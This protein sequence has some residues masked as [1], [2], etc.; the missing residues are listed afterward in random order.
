MSPD[1][2]G[3]YRQDIFN[4]ELAAWL[5][6]LG[7]MSPEFVRQRDNAAFW[8]GWLHSQ[9]PD[10]QPG[11]LG[12][13]YI[14]DPSLGRSLTDTQVTLPAPFDTRSV[15]CLIELYRSR[16]SKHAGRLN[17]IMV[18]A[19]D[20]ASGEEKRSRQREEAET[21]GRGRRGDS[22]L[23]SQPHALPWWTITPFG[24]AE[25][26]YPGEDRTS[27]QNRP[28]SGE[29]DLQDCQAEGI[30]AAKRQLARI[31]DGQAPEFDHLRGR[32]NAGLD[33]SSIPVCDVRIAD[34]SL[35]ASAFAKAGVVESLL[36]GMW[37]DERIEWRLLRLAVDGLGFLAMPTRIPEVL[38][39]Q[40][41]LRDGLD[42]LRAF[43]ERD[44]LCGTEVYRDEY[45]PVFVVPAFDDDHQ[46][47][48]FDAWLLGRL[49]P[50]WD[51]RTGSEL[52]WEAL[53][54]K[55]FGL[56]SGRGYAY[57]LGSLLRR[58]PPP[59]SASPGA[60]TADWKHLADGHQTE[61]CSACQ[62]RPIGT[63]PHAQA[64]RI[65][66]VCYAGRTKR[67]ESWLRQPFSTI[68][69]E[70]VADRNGRIAVVAARF[71]AED[72]LSREDERPSYMES[73]VFREK[74]TGANPRNIA[75][76]AA[77]TRRLFETLDDFWDLLLRDWAD[78]LRADRKRVQLTPKEGTWDKHNAYDL[79]SRTSHIGIA[80]VWTGEAFVIVENPERLARN[81]S[82]HED[83]WRESFDVWL[84]TG[85]RRE[86]TAASRAFCGSFEVRDVKEWGAPFTRVIEIEHDPRQFLALVPADAALSCIGKVEGRYGERFGRVRNRLAVDI[87]II[88]AGVETPLRA[89]LDAARRGLRRRS[90]PAEWHV[91]CATSVESANAG[92]RSVRLR[93]DNGV[94]W[95]IPLDFDFE[96]GAESNGKYTRKH[97]RTP[98]DYFAYFQD[99]DGCIAHAR[100]LQ[101][102]DPVLVEPSTFDFEFLD[103]SSRR[104]DLSYDESGRRRA[105]DRLHRPMLLERIGELL[106]LWDLL[107]AR[108]ATRQ[109]K[110]LDGLL[111]ARSEDWGTLPSSFVDDVLRNL[112]PK[113]G[114]TGLSHRERRHLHAAARSGLL[115]DCLEWH[116]GICKSQRN[117]IEE[118]VE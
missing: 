48:G 35:M 102:G 11:Y 93:F 76:S 9:E 36:T 117:R 8:C 72:W 19:H 95:K 46:R 37:R 115:Y 63:S 68:W 109:L 41:R 104:F 91:Q 3:Q 1:G 96:S 114:S 52:P 116:L 40:T 6:L 84:P 92:S 7:R 27:S 77:R 59:P 16:R 65:C 80:A 107:R 69:M 31:A 90:R 112:E 42:A 73:T 89:L 82:D 17:Q 34:V 79:E 108:F 66:N 55:P 100:D 26:I 50:Y 44:L 10:N 81:L 22:E 86:G 4:V 64:R 24:F 28:H 58:Q 105:P 47:A 13:R 23:L 67:V 32:L 12:L 20:E 38:A 29:D 98:D 45:G 25:Q 33:D 2:L 85:Y 15:A 111:D 97:E 61:P 70:E 83:L 21:E 5:H 43:I 113:P 99:S 18:R 103:S 54:S 94:E 39:R 78:S 14:D 106:Q 101:P 57:Q 110:I 87:T 62:S 71:R 51:Q 74:Y 30:K 88:V 53:F 118:E 56:D 60:I 49:Q 75:P